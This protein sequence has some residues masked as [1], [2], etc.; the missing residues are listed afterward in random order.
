MWCVG[1]CYI[2]RIIIER[3]LAGCKNY[4]FS[5]RNSIVNIVDE[6]EDASACGKDGNG[7][8]TWRFWM[9]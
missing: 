3:T 7:E 6:E 1:R 2:I 4:Y 8:V 5:E 9:I